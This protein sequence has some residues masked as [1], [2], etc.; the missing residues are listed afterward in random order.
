MQICTRVQILK[1]PFTWP[2]IHP[3]C[4]FAPRVQICTRV[5]IAHMNEALNDIL[6]SPAQVRQVKC[7]LSASVPIGFRSI[8]YVSRYLE[9]MEYRDHT[10][11]FFLMHL[12]LPWLGVFRTRTGLGFKRL[13]R[14]TANVIDCN[15]HA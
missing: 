12:H 6:S 3:G 8:F 5:Q 13:L 15:K 4:K 2:K 9:I 14:D 1:T 10:C 7:P 11:F